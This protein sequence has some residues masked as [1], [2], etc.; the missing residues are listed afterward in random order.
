MK[1]EKTLLEA[2]VCL[3]IKNDEVLLGLKMKKIGEGCRN[4][5]GGGIEKGE[6]IRVAAVRELE[7]ETGKKVGNV[8][9][10]ASP[11]SLEKIAIIDFKN[12]K[13]DGTF[14]VCHVHFFLVKE[15]TGTTRNTDEMVDPRF[16]KITNL[17][18]NDMMPADVHFFPLILQGKKILGQATYGPFQKEL[19]EPVVMTEVHVLPED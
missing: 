8:F 6:N 14:F 2:T 15:W 18:F 19:L 5:Y 3:V 12:F 17:P 1:E 4:G 13:S 9:I 16:F 10:T 11:E 7:E